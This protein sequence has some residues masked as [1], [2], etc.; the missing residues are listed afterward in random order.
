MGT[1]SATDPPLAGAAMSTESPFQTLEGVEDAAISIAY[2]AIDDPSVC[3]DPNAFESVPDDAV[4]SVVFVRAERTAWALTDARKETS[5]QSLVFFD[6][7]RIPLRGGIFDHV[8]LERHMGMSDRVVVVTMDPKTLMVGVFFLRT[9]DSVHLSQERSWENA[10]LPVHGYLAREAFYR[11]P[12]AYQK[13]SGETVRA[14]HRAMAAIPSR[15]EWRPPTLGID[16]KAIER[17]LKR[18][19]WRFHRDVSPSLG[20][21]FAKTFEHE[22]IRLGHRPSEAPEV[23]LSP[24]DRDVWS[25]LNH[26]A[27]YENIPL[28]ELITESLL[29]SAE[30]ETHFN[31]SVILGPW[32]R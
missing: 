24:E 2:E 29:T 27:H 17:L 18:H 16:V 15:G 22:S 30:G 19:G 20:G 26:M 7:D 1:S 5:F 9:L 4:F 12:L 32:R 21:S 10:S 28:G 6:R 13:P 23:F 8:L 3:I 11:S 25:V 14:M 31:P